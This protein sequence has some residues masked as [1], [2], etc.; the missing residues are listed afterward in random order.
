MVL[1]NPCERVV[2]HPLKEV[3]THRLRT[4]VLNVEQR[5]SSEDCIPQRAT[6][7]L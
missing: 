5:G 6:L 2:Q 7:D 1:D 3:V 4:A